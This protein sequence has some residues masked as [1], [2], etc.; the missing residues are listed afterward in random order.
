MECPAGST[1]PL[2]S[3]ARTDCQCDPGF[4]GPSGGPCTPCE[5]GTYKEASG[6][7]Q[8]V[9]CPQGYTSPPESTNSSSCLLQCDAGSFGPDGGPC[10]LCPAGKF[11]PDA[12]SAPCEL[13]CPEN[14]DS[15]PGSTQL[16]DCKC[17]AGYTGP[18]PT[19]SDGSF[20]SAPTTSEGSVRLEGC[21]SD[22]CCRVEIYHDSRWGTVCDDDWG[23]EDAAVTCRQLGC[24]TGTSVLE[25]GGGSGMIWMDEVRCVG[26]EG[27]LRDCSF[28][29]GEYN[30]GD[31]EAA[32]GVCWGI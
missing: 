7:A 15:Q 19:T 27:S 9:P 11:K 21:N 1:S 3:S 18:G 29:W 23:N 12:G 25:F 5:S 14:T 30:C 4:R 28:G 13:D 22:K 17:N 32:A 16:T 20:G 31:R 8:C 2:G 10:E 24:G 6:D 26:S